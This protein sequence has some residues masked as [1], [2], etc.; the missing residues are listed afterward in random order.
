MKRALTPLVLAALCLAVAGPLRAQGG[1]SAR[2]ATGL[3]D[4]RLG[5][6]LGGEWVIPLGAAPTLPSAGGP[7]VVQTRDWLLTGVLGAGMAIHFDPGDV[8][9]SAL[10]ILAL[11]RRL[12]GALRAGVGGAFVAAPLSG[13]PTTRIEFKDAFVLDAGW[14]WGRHGADGAFVMV[15]IDWA[16]FRDTGG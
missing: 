14:L 6:Y 9:L 1:A 7:M 16:L 2:I 4:D 12:S 13:G 11:E 8:D 10:A 3:V 15:E 5:V